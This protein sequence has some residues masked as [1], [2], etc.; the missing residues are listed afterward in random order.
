MSSLA[1]LPSRKCLA[2]NI[3]SMPGVYDLAYR[4]AASLGIGLLIG[5]ERE[6]RKGEGPARSPAGIRTFMIA[7]LSG[8][9]SFA[10]GGM[11][12]LAI[13]FL[14]V[15][16]LCAIGYMRTEEQDPGLTTETALLLTVLL[17]GFALKEPVI[18]SALAVTVAIALMARTRIHHFIRDV[19][20]EEELTDALIFG[21][22]ALVV[23]PLVPDRFVGPFSATN[24]RTIWKV[25]IL[26]MSISA[27][28]HIAVRL[29]GPRFGLPLAGL[30][31]GFVSSVATIA[32]MGA[33]ARKDPLVSRPAV[34]GAVLSTVATVIQLAVVLAAT[35]WPA[36]S[37][38][39]I[40]LVGA[41][42]AAIIYGALFTFRNIRQGVPDSMQVGRVFSLKT[43][44]IFAGTIALVQFASAALDA[45]FGR[46]GVIAAAAAAG[47][48]DTHS[49][50][51]SVASLV[52]SGKLSAQESAL[53]ILAGLTTN[54][55]TKMVVGISSGGRRFAL[56]IIPG[57]ILVV[58]GAWFGAISSL[59]R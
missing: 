14:G 23:L 53:P 5:A 48:A 21:A 24:P 40:S 26:I 7:S 49:A 13:T 37:V 51:V 30:A 20:S 52:A 1:G 18:A 8:G 56:Q 58:L 9:V 31:S 2:M 32:S 43:A 12:L 59:F 57:Q 41:G 3:P 16:G 34:A 6:R 19:L 44:L 4:F 47:F 11:P 29:L 15:A 27:G 35:S 28:G 46:A 25:V 33:R 42:L 38:L 22:A 17:G 54:T 10:L 55:A 39:K 50:A 36:F 45:E